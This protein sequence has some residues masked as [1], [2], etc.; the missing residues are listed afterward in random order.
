[1]MVAADEIFDT[2]KDTFTEYE[3]EIERLKQENCLMRRNCS[4]TETCHDAQTAEVLPDPV[5]SELS[6]TQV[7]MEV[8]TVMSHEPVTPASFIISPLSEEVTRQET[9]QCL[10]PLPAVML[11]NEDID[12]TDSQSSVTVKSERGDDQAGE[13]NSSAAQSGSVWNGELS[14]P[15]QEPPSVQCDLETFEGVSQRR[16]RKCQKPL[17]QIS[18]KSLRKTGRLQN[19]MLVDQDDRPFCCGSCGGRFKSKFNLSEH[20]RIH[21]G[22]YRYSCPKC[23]RGFSRSNHVRKHLKGNKCH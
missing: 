12:G 1:M 8:A 3:K 7:K 11:K 6:E 9:S 19:H 16:K 17:N 5:C 10:S 2:V 14:V 22:D 4:C 15:E 18:G 13:S 20:E 21:K 23:G